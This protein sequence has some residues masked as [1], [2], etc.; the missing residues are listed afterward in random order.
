M[1]LEKLPIHERVSPAVLLELDSRAR[2]LISRRV[3]PVI[4]NV[5]MGSAPVRRL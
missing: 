1:C 5:E 3:V 2:P 4:E